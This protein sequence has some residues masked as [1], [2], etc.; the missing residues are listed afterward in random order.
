MCF[1]LQSQFFSISALPAFGRVWPQKVQPIYKS[2]IQLPDCSTVDP[3]TDDRDLLL[4]ITRREDSYSELCKI[5]Q[6]HQLTQCHPAAPLAVA[7][8]R[9]NGCVDYLMAAPAMFKESSMVL[10]TLS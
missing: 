9:P 2:D 6:R 10:A 8:S 7:N 5:N 1:S 4:G 3:P